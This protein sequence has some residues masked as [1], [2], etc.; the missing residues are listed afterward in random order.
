MV[1][2]RKMFPLNLIYVVLYYCILTLI[3]NSDDNTQPGG[4]LTPGVVPVTQ[5]DPKVMTSTCP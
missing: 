2:N 4:D 3:F 5:S 1:V